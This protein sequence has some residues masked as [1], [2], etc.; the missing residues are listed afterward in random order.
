MA[1]RGRPGAHESELLF[2]YWQ[3]HK[4]F[5]GLR[6]GSPSVE[7]SDLDDPREPKPPSLTGI[8]LLDEE[9]LQ[10]YD[11]ECMKPRKLRVVPRFTRAIAG[12]R[13]RWDRLKRTASVRSIRTICRTSERWLN[14]RWQGRAFVERLQG[15]EAARAFLKARRD[16]R[17]PGGGKQSRP[18]SDEKCVDYFA[19]IMAGIENGIGH[20][21]A[22]ERLGPILR[23]EALR[24]EGLRRLVNELRPMEFVIEHV[25]TAS[26]KPNTTIHNNILTNP[27]R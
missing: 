7:V 3:W 2:W 18:K 27:P 16:S 12:E 26:F 1:K 13:K 23:S 9:R 22:I 5:K 4:V 20:R 25:A 14:P 8:P 19:R 6:D 24:Q 17:F 15:P 10:T 21:Q 11:T